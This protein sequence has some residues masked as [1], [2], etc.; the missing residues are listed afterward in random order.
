MGGINKALIEV[1]GVPV[2]KRT[3]AI[4]EPLFAEIIVAG[5]PPGDPLQGN[6]I[7]VNDNYRGLGPLAGIEAALRVSRSEALFVF[8]GDMPWLSAELIRLQAVNYLE[9]PSDILAARYEGLSEPLHS[10]YRKSIHPALAIYLEEGNS[11]AIIDFYPV[12][13]TRFFDLP[14]TAETHRAMTNINRPGDIKF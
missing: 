4:L 3:L 10:I 7:T 14:L 13:K 9:N 1:E 11:P 8:G 12:A 2:I 5:W 6:I